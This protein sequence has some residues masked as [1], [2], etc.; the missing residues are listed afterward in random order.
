MLGGDA[1]RTVFDRLMHG[2][3]SAKYNNNELLKHLLWLALCHQQDL[4]FLFSPCGTKEEWWWGRKQLVFLNV[5]EK[6]RALRKRQWS[7]RIIKVLLCDYSVKGSVLPHAEWW[8]VGLLYNLE[9]SRFK[10]FAYDMTIKMIEHWCVK[11]NILLMC[12][13]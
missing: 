8:I 5:E 10:R 3:K 12:I 1:K 11:I 2:L 4:S 13:F 9:C 7:V 6:R